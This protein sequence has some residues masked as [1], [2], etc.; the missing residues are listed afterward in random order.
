[1]CVVCSL[2]LKMDSTSN[3]KNYHERK[4]T[5]TQLT[6]DPDQVV[7]RFHENSGLQVEINNLLFTGELQRDINLCLFHECTVDTRTVAFG[8]SGMSATVGVR[9]NKNQQRRLNVELPNCVVRGDDIAIRHSGILGPLWD[10]IRQPLQYPFNNQVKGFN[11]LLTSKVQG[12][13]QGFFDKGVLIPLPERVCFTQ[14]K[15]EYHDG[16]VVVGGD[17]NLTPA[18]KEKVVKGFSN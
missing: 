1:M 4:L 16:F 9:L 3:S 6:M 17:L 11:S 8:G 10:L 14:G 15:L 18:G 5:L 7:L 13:L 12:F 2:C